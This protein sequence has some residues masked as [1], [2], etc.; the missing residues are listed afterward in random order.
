LAGGRYL[1]GRLYQELKHV[2]RP[3]PPGLTTNTLQIRSKPFKEQS[4]LRAN[5]MSGYQ[6]PTAVMIFW[7]GWFARNNSTEKL[8]NRVHSNN[9][10]SGLG[11]QINGLKGIRVLESFTPSVTGAESV[12]YKTKANT[13]QPVL[14]KQAAVTVGGGVNLD[15]LNFALKTSNLYSIGAA[16]G[17][18]SIA[19]GWSQSGG[20]APLSSYY[21][22]A[23]DQMLEYKIV[24]ADGRLLVA[25]NVTN[26]DLFWALR[27]GGGG[28]WGVVVE[29][30]LKVC[31]LC[32]PICPL[33]LRP[34]PCETSTSANSYSGIPTT[35]D[36]KLPLLA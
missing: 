13:I 16:H 18:V 25:N 5:T 12:D 17:S 19:G 14:G 30:T 3:R 22:L 36:T 35:K 6:S 8:L 24:T 21:G 27:G 26:Q 23:V 34:N 4:N 28:T 15:E 7:D 33:E 2:C 9:A 31:V 1:G 11:I 10:P 32:K 29:A 20:H